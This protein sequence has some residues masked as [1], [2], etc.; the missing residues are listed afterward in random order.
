MVNLKKMLSKRRVVYAPNQIKG[1][2]DLIV[3]REYKLIVSDEKGNKKETRFILEEIIGG[4]FIRIEG[5]WIYLGE[6]GIIPFLSKDK[7]H[8]YNYII[9]N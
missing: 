1:I 2:G 5:Y 9:F 4:E 6:Y 7:W 3:G 8:K